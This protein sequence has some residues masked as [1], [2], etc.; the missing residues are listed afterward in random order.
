[1]VL[2]KGRERELG[3]GI[4]CRMGEW[5]KSEDW[6]SNGRTNSGS[7]GKDQGMEEIG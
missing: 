1:M 2:G 3:Y 5:K 7:G 4:G 6:V